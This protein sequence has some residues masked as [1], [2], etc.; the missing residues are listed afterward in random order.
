[1]H[2]CE[3]K[4]EKIWTGKGKTYKKKRFATTGKQSQFQ[5]K[6][7]RG[8]GILLRTQG[9]RDKHKTKEGGKERMTIFKG[10]IESIRQRR[11]GRG[12]WAQVAKKIFWWRPEGGEIGVTLIRESASRQNRLTEPPTLRFKRG[13]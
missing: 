2:L 13:R 8:E 11:E 7:R 5:S 10:S 1:M 4:I 6:G 3:T 12:K 9:V